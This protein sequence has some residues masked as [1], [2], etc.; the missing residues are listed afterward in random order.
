MVERFTLTQVAAGALEAW[1]DVVATRK[2]NRVAVARCLAKMKMRAAAAALEAWV[3]LAEDRKA[4]RRFL[5]KMMGRWRNKEL[6]GGWA[7]WHLVYSVEKMRPSGAVDHEELRRLRSMTTDLE[8]ERKNAA[9]RRVMRRMVNGVVAQ[10][11]V[12]LT[13]LLA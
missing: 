4:A 13:C 2:H 11:C 3:G 8:E 5:N 12:W 10:A 9:T 7:Q 1:V 6:A